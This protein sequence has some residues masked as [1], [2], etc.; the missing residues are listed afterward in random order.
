MTCWLTRGEM[1]QLNRSLALYGNKHCVSCDMTKSVLQFHVSRAESDGLS[2][3]C[4][5][6]ACAASRKYS[7]DHAESK[8]A[9]DRAWR[10]ANPDKVAECAKRM[11]ILY[12]EKRTA[13]VAVSNAVRDGRL[14]KPNQCSVCGGKGSP[15]AHHPE[16]GKPLEVVWMCRK[17]HRSLHKRLDKIG[18]DE[19]RRIYIAGAYSADNVIDMLENMRRGMRLAAEVLMTGFAPFTP[20][21]DYHHILQLQGKERLLLED[22]YAYSMAWLEVS[23]AV[24]IVPGWEHSRGTKTEIEAAEARAIP[25]FFSIEDLLD[26]RNVGS[27]S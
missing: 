7:A 4:K 18:G 10:T 5:E 27:I 9:S 19:M 25:V 8:A 14:V 24:L 3:K 2:S 6:C 20:W 1:T 12:P 17:C 26:W 11:N 22:M 21:H 15:E 13:R 16:Y 23:D